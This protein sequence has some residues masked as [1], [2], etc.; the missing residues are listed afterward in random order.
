VENKHY[1]F[2]WSEIGEREIAEREIEERYQTSP[3]WY[4]KK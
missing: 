3:V 1:V 4:A 2:G